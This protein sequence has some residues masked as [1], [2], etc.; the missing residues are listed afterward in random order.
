[1]IEAKKGAGDVPIVA[2]GGIRTSGDMVKALAIGASAVMLGN[3]LAGT[4]EAPGR[5]TMWNGRKVK[6]YRGMASFAAYEDKAKN[7]GYKEIE[8]FTAEGIDQSFVPYKGAVKDLLL[9]WEG[10]IK[11]GLSYCG[12]KN[13]RELWQKAEFIK[14]T[15]STIKENL[16]HDVEVV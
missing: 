11:S 7:S 5:L 2:D 3:L 14:I 13:I 12:A 8:G 15:P 9:S 4:D 1:V 6:L 16:P 10:G